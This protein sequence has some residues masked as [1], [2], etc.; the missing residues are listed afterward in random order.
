MEERQDFNDCKEN[1]RRH[2]IQKVSYKIAVPDAGGEDGFKIVQFI[3][4]G[5]IV[6]LASSKIYNSKI[7]YYKKFTH[8]YSCSIICWLNWGTSSRA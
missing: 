3:V 4:Q 7:Y 6:I 1:G 5:S 2:F 8:F